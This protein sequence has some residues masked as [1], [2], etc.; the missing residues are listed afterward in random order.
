VLA[1][2]CDARLL[3]PAEKKP[4]GGEK[5]YLRQGDFKLTDMNGKQVSLDQFKGKAVYMISGPAGAV[6]ADE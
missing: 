3:K 5:K 2:L 1:S 6:P 4:I